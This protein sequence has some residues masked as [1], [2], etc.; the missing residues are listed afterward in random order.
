LALALL[1]FGAFSIRGLHSRTGLPYVHRWGE[2]TI[3]GRSLEMVKTGDLNP[4]WFKYGGPTIYLE[5]VVD[6][7]HYVWLRGQPESGASVGSLEDILL[8]KQMGS[9]WLLSHPSFLL[10]N[11]LALSLVGVLTIVMTVGLARMFIGRWWAL[12]AGATLTALPSHV[13]VSTSVRPDALATLFTLGA[14]AAAVRFLRHERPGSWIASLLFAGLAAA[15]K[16]NAAMALLAPWSALA[17]AGWRRSSG[18]RRWM[19]LAAFG[20]PILAFLAGN[21][22]CVVELTTFLEHAGDEYHHYHQLGQPG[23][24][25]EPGLAHAWIQIRQLAQGLGAGSSILGWPLMLLA[26]PGAARL[27]R[28]VEGAVVCFVPLAFF[29]FMVSTKVVFEHNFAL[30]GPF[31]GLALA[32]GARAIATRLRATTSAARLAWLATAVLIAAAPFTK[33]WIQA[34]R[35]ARTPDTRSRI[36]DAVNRLARERGWERVALADELEMHPLDRARLEIESEQLKLEGIRAQES[37]FDALVVP[38]AIGLRKGMVKA[39]EGLEDE[40]YLHP[41]RESVTTAYEEL[42][43]RMEAKRAFLPR[44]EVVFEIEG[45]PTPLGAM[46]VNPGLRIVLPG[47]SVSGD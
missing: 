21:P 23:Q 30:L 14:V 15:T 7:V 42:E 31:V 1:L 2:T 44:G 18:L 35:I 20:L 24:I 39:A 45:E 46:S 13:F 25:A 5:A 4:H 32:A 12:L 9:R 26:L 38:M 36:V 17:L 16:Y 40:N 33:S 10:W 3:V 22:F 11:R 27:I 28:R 8:P 34:G 37:R 47:P 41:D 6:A 19:P 43:R 29:L